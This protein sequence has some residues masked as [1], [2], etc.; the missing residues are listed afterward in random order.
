MKPAPFEY[1][2]PADVAEALD[3]LAGLEEAKVLAG[4]QSLV[5]LMN[6][7]LATPAHLVDISR[8]AELRH[9]DVTER[10]VVVGASITHAELMGHEA[11]NEA[12]PLLGRALRFVA[13]EVVRNRG[14]TC[15]SLAHADP[16]GELTAVLALLGGEVTLASQSGERTVGAA[17]FFVGYL[18]SACGDEELVTSALFPRLGEGSRSTFVEVA[19]RHGDYAMCGAAAAVEVA[20]DGTIAAARLAYISMAPGPVV[21]DVGEVVQGRAPADVDLAGMYDLVSSVVDPRDDIHASA[22][23]RR[24]LAGVL[25]GRAITEAAA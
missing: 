17:D 14:T 6:F 8:L 11:A 15:G 4:G 19:R 2:R 20:G 25:A 7:R 23:Y 9:V 24:H 22:N 12:C 16:S 3:M 21:I 1:H 10:G 13:H 5:P 18:Q